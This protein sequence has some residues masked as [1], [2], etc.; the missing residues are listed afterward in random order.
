MGSGPYR[1]EGDSSRYHLYFAYCL[2][3]AA[4]SGTAVMPLRVIASAALLLL[5]QRHSCV[6]PC[7]VTGAP[8]TPFQCAARGMYSICFRLCLAPPG[9][10]LRG[11]LRIYFFPVTA[12]SYSVGFV[13]AAFAFA[14]AFASATSSIIPPI[15]ETSNGFRGM[16][17][18][19]LPVL[20]SALSG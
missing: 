9:I 16:I 20:I 3:A 12:F 19:V 8:V 1:I 6:Y 4:S 11:Y 17:R 14:S 15:S 2:T 13:S 5:Y 7:A 18:I 10:S